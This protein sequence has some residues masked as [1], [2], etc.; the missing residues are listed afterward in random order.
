M[1]DEAPL[2][3][4]TR[5][6]LVTALAYGLRF[7][8]R[9]KAHRQATEISAQIAAETLARYLDHA[10]FVV[11]RRPSS[12]RTARQKLARDAPYWRSLPV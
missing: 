3:P 2:A 7:D 9:G 8:E 11:M 10:G 5:D 12:R 4:A 1:P 6:E